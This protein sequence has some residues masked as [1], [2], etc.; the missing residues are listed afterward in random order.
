M[1]DIIIEGNQ[2]RHNPSEMNWLQLEFKRHKV[3]C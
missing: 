2:H 3:S 1:G